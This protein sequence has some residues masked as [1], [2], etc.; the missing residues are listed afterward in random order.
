MFDSHLLQLIQTPNSLIVPPEM[1]KDFVFMF[2]KFSIVHKNVEI[3]VIK[4]AW[5]LHGW[6]IVGDGRNGVEAVCE[7]SFPSKCHLFDMAYN[8]ERCSLFCTIYSDSAMEYDGTVTGGWVLLEVIGSI[9]D[10]GMEVGLAEDVSAVEGWEYNDAQF[11][12]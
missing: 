7:P 9:E 1:I 6:L 12:K 11:Q 2:S 5:V 4:R 8:V 10:G 3:Q